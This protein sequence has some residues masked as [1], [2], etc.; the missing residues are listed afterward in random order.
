MT[1]NVST[2]LPPNST[3]QLTDANVDSTIASLEAQITELETTEAHLLPAVR[4]LEICQKSL[5]QARASLAHVRSR[6]MHVSRLPDDVLALIF[7]AGPI[8]D[9]YCD[10]YLE[11]KPKK[12]PFSIL[13]SHVSRIWREVAIRNPFL[14]TSIHI[15]S[16]KPHDL[17]LMYLNRSKSCSL[18][19]RYTCHTDRISDFDPSILQLQRCR[20]LTISSYW[21]C[22]TFHIC[23][24]LEKEAIPRLVSFTMEMEYANDGYEDDFPS[25]CYE[26]FGGGAPVL[27]SVQLCGISLRSFKLP[28]SAL[29]DLTLDTFELA[30]EMTFGEFFDALADIAPTLITLQLEGIVLRVRSG[31]HCCPINFPSLT[32][33][34]IRFSDYLNDEYDDRHFIP[35]LWDCINVPALESLTLSIM[36]E[37][38][39][40]TSMDSLRRQ[41]MTSTTKGGLKSLHLFDINIDGYADDLTLACLNLS[42]LTLTERATVPVLKFILEADRQ[43]LTAPSNNTH[44][45]LLWPNLHTLSV[46]SFQDDILRAVVLGRKAL[47]LP[48]VELYMECSAGTRSWYCQHVETVGPFLWPTT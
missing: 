47:G 39:F 40:H 8:P 45:R 15:I 3:P 28:I 30:T 27:S 1:S 44:T 21:Y 38:Q 12:L 13:V 18:D 26:L 25:Q 36:D 41:H 46:V 10:Y 14:W 24:R 5:E 16:S 42:N 4:K 6:K 23:Q 29:T 34:V 2:P 48:L 7:E 11:K 17:Y 19:M 31:E 32:S 37:D 35:E 20:H 43:R 22:S 33:L 9:L